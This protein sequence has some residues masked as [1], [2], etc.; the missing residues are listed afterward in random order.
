[1]KKRPSVLTILKVCE[2][3]I[4]SAVRDSVLSQL[5]ANMTS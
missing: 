3:T 1:M 2:S 5:N 4:T